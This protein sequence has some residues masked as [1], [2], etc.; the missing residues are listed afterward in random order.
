M[1]LLDRIRTAQRDAGEAACT[2]N[3]QRLGL[4]P[5]PAPVESQQDAIIRLQGENQVLRDLLQLTLKPLSAGLFGLDD[6]EK[7]DKLSDLI[8]KIESALKPAPTFDGMES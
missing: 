8:D 7:A 1:S 6:E 2:A 5:A 4:I 3:L